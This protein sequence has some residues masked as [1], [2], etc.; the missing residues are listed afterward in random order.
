MPDDIT[1][2]ELGRRMDALAL[3]IREWRQ[4]TVGRLE[5]ES[6]QQGIERRFVQAE[7]QAAITAADVSK[8]RADVTKTEKDRDREAG[9]RR[10]TVL[11][12]IASPLVGAL[13]AWIVAGGLSR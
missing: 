2:G 6:D 13:M 9:Q 10:F 1:L 3:E 11:G 4:S 7:A 5:Y 12:L 8:L